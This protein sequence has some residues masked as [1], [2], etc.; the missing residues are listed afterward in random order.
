MTS[1]KMMMYVT[2]HHT[3]EDGYL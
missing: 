2:W 3:Y 1:F